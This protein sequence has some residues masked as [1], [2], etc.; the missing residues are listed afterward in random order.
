MF[1][2]I[3]VKTS[4]QIL[5][6]IKRFPYAFFYII[7]LTGYLL[8]IVE[9]TPKEEIPIKISLSAFIAYFAS[10]CFRIVVEIK[11]IKFWYE[12]IFNVLLICLLVFFYFSIED[13]TTSKIL[14]KYFISSLYL[15]FAIFVLPFV[16]FKN[17][18]NEF[19]QYSYNLVIRAILINIFTGIIYFGIIIA[20]VSLTYLLDLKNSNYFYAYTIILI[21]GLFAVPLLLAWIPR[22]FTEISEKYPNY[23]KILSFYIILPLTAIYFIILYIYLARIIINW[24][25]PRQI[26]S[27]LVISFSTLGILNFL[28]L[29]PLRKNSFIKIVQRIFY[30]AVLPLLILLFVSI[31]K[32]IEQ[33]GITEIRYFAVILALWLA[34]SVVYSIY[35]KFV[36]IKHIIISL[37]ILSVFSI[38]G[39]WSAFSISLTSQLNRLD[40]TI[41]F[42]RSQKDILIKNDTMFLNQKKTNNIREII[43]YI[44][45]N[46]GQ[47]ELAKNFGLKKIDSLSRYYITDSILDQLKVV[48]SYE[49]DTF[50]NN[51]Y[52]SYSY[53]YYP[54][55]IFIS[56]FDYIIPMELYSSR[57]KIDNDN[58]SLIFDKFKL[59][60][61]YK[62][63]TI[64]TYNL[65][66][67]VNY[68]NSYKE[69]DSIEA[70][71]LVSGK[72]FKTQLVILNL[73]GNTNEYS[74]F[75]GFML[76]KKY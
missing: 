32:R 6:G 46:H 65:E 12:A 63:D 60:L 17:N 36:K 15:I 67:F 10:I 69:L 30:V 34:F 45:E 54:K 66:K 26:I 55:I 72:N 44:V 27:Y 13:V 1:K 25:I 51:L 50:D 22:D 62:Q 58:F 47:N 8:Y 4:N 39:P 76:I 38:Y 23:L 43:D 29:Y 33:Y 28:V 35:Y 9:H 7:L 49:L 19:W 64:S 75:K 59:F 74:Y 53:Y 2:N 73:N 68:N 56:D 20:Y 18:E 5:N 61:L 14:I 42:Y 16:F 3:I 11:N 24:T 31:S 52:S 40:D 70:N 21:L 37:I 48:H 71:I 41:K 57:E